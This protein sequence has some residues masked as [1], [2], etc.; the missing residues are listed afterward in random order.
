M[1]VDDLL[2]QKFTE[3]ADDELLK[4]VYLVPIHE[5]IVGEDG[6]ISA[7]IMADYLHPTDAAYTQIF[8]PVLDKVLSLVK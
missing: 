4:N 3:D 2:I 5:N 8:T 7:D 6:T 1:D